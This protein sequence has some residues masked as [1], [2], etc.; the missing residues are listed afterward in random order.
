MGFKLNRL[1]TSSSLLRIH[2]IFIL[3][4]VRVRGVMLQLCLRDS[5]RLAT[6]LQLFSVTNVSTQ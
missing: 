4:F 2:F 5:H 1:R 6:Q 3:P